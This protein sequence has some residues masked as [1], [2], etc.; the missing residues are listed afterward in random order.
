MVTV[1]ERDG[2]LLLCEP[3][4]SRDPFRELAEHVSQ[5][6]QSTVMQQLLHRITATEPTPCSFV[7]TMRVVPGALREH[8]LALVRSAPGE[9]FSGWVAG[10]AEELTASTSLSD[11][12]DELPTAALLR[13]RPQLIKVL[14]LPPGY[15]VLF[16]GHAIAAVIDPHG[17]TIEFESN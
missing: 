6:L 12:L 11:D 1:V 2:D 17:E 10:P 8:R 16:D 9:G 5:T 15:T 4:F 13:R 14:S 7:D 3:E